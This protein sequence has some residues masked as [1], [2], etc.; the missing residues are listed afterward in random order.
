[1]AFVSQ[2]K[3]TSTAANRV[4]Q[5]VSLPRFLS[6]LRL[7]YRA[8]LYGGLKFG[9]TF[10]I[11]VVALM[12]FVQDYALF[13]VPIYEPKRELPAGALEQDIKTPDG[14][15]LKVFDFR[16]E[17]PAP[18]VIFFHGNAA[19]SGHE[20]PRAEFMYK[21]GFNVL[22]AEYRGYGGSSG[23][24]SVQNILDDALVQFDWLKRQGADKV[25]VAGHSLG[26][27]PAIYLAANRDVAA[28][29][30]EAPY[31]QLVK[32]AA[33]RYPLLPVH[34]LFRNHL[35]PAEFIKEVEEP[36]LIMH[37]SDDRTISIDL[38][39]ELYAASNKTGPFIEMLEASH[40]LRGYGSIPKT[41][42]FFEQN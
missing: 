1:M 34:T 5:I 40:H 6:I 27:G 23:S 24:P 17:E 2:K 3:S 26:T 12:Y 33:D 9:V 8:L 13:R 29:A 25:Y 38:G 35:N 37:G 20:L 4:K 39:R 32:A 18:Y 31:S 21:R 19:S 11:V 14:H 10:Y 7:R 22:L 15:V 41:L 30:L 28:V 36:L 16:H 42:E